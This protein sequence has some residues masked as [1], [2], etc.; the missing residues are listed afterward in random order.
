MKCVICNKEITG[1]GNNA[2]PVKSGYCCDTC[3][4]QVIQARYIQAVKSLD[5]QVSKY[6]NNK[7]DK[8]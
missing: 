7:E 4:V 3:N 5:K 8:K 2:E 6:F 1:P